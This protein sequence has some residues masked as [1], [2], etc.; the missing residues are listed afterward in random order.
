PAGLYAELAAVDGLGG[1]RGGNRLR[2]VVAGERDRP[3]V[4]LRVG[5][6]Q[7]Q[8]RR[9]VGDKGRPLLARLGDFV[10]GAAVVRHGDGRV[11]LARRLGQR[12]EQAGGSGVRANGLVS[13]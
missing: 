13:F 7:E 9:R 1:R 6:L 11:V 4:L 5:D 3:A 12:A 10:G 2:G 8:R